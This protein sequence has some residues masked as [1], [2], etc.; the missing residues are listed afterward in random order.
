MKRLLVGL[1]VILSSLTVATG[2]ARE[3][4]G[5][6]GAGNGGG[7]LD[8]PGLPLRA[9][10]LVLPHD[11]DWHL[12]V[13]RNRAEMRRHL[14]QSDRLPESLKAAV[15]AKFD[16]F[17]PSET[18]EETTDERTYDEFLSIAVPE[19]CRIVQVARFHRGGHPLRAPR[20]RDLS[21]EQRAVLEL[22]E[23]VYTVGFE[24]YEHANSY[25]TRKL[26]QLV[27]A[28]YVQPTERDRIV[29]EFTTFRPMAV[30][31]GY[32]FLAQGDPACPKFAMLVAYEGLAARI[33]L[34][35]DLFSGQ[36]EW[37]YLP[38]GYPG[39]MQP[40]VFERTDQG[41][42]AEYGEWS[43]RVENRLGPGV[44]LILLNDPLR[45]VYE[46]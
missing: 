41:L 46:H 4:G 35:N 33:Q 8:C 42:R 24:K 2:W 16:A 23:A 37:V 39:P 3:G 19:G 40:V 20:Y 17:G 11:S 30:P 6:S 10:D 25:P 18:W 36:E 32:Y 22:H 15:L 13:P 26:V 43:I 12:Q 1:G 38:E 14:V 28:A 21:R 31:P 45:C 44:Q 9:L 27:L 29:T 7:A 5:G 34:E